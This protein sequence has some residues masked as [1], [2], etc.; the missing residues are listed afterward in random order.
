MQVA[1]TALLCVCVFVSY[2]VKLNHNSHHNSHHTHT[3]IR[4]V[5]ATRMH[6]AYIGLSARMSNAVKHREQAGTLARPYA[7]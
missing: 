2:A 5:V 1:V 7:V 4:A 6:D 3:H